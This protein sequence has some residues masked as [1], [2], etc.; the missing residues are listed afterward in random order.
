MDI[1]I[2]G[3]VWPVTWKKKLTVRGTSGRQS[4]MGGGW[5]PMPGPSG[6][7]RDEAGDSD[8]LTEACW[9]GAWE[10]DV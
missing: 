6:S 4:G 5:S 9:K 10:A 1:L 2:S 7:G 8:V 3:A